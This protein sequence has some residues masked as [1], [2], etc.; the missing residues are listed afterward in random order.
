MM[1]VFGALDDPELAALLRQGKVGVMPTDTVYGL[2]A[3]AHLPSAVGRLYALKHRE[4]K[5]GTTIVADVGQL[6][7]LGIDPAYVHRVSHLWPAPLSVILPLPKQLAYIHQGRGD[8]PFRVVSDK[9]VQQLL[10]STGPLVTSSANQPGKPPATNLAEAQAY[11]GSQ[12][13][14]YVDGGDIGNRAPS[15]IIKLDPDGAITL[16]RQGAASINKKGLLQ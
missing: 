3:S 16:I 14:F 13:D 7:E 6:A 5:P 10:K 15:T 2:V 12:A 9:P 11:F 8:S 4:H 1:K